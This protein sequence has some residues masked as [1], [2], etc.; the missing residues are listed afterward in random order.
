MVPTLFLVILL[1]LGPGVLQAQEPRVTALTAT[2]NGT[3]VSVHFS[4]ENAFDNEELEKALRSGLP[5]GFTY[6]IEMVRRRPRWFDT[7]AAG[8][9]IEVVCTFNSLTH[10]YLLN[11]RR[12]RRL[13]RSETFTDLERLKERMTTIEEEDLL[14]IGS[15]RPSKLVVRAKADVTR[16]FLFYV[17]P[18]EISTAW[19]E[20][21]VS[22]VR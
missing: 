2:L 8:S 16:G 18:W 22:R 7:L 3:Q 21:R 10:E 5:T 12:D 6:H 14:P 4:L 15:F 1:A 19:K 11:Y 17:I 13:V 9:T 20:A